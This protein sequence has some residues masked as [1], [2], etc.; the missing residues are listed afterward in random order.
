[1]IMPSY[2]LC[3]TSSKVLYAEPDG[4]VVY[5]KDED[6]MLMPYSTL[7]INLREPHE[8][9][10]SYVDTND[11]P[12]AE[13]FI[14]D[15]KLGKPTGRKMRSGYCEYPQYQFDLK[16]IEKYQLNAPKTKTKDKSRKRDEAR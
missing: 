11:N 13:K 5:F 6:S 4:L 9:N 1:M 14:T 16:E 2:F 15:N 8:P 3:L 7:T 12:W 10:C